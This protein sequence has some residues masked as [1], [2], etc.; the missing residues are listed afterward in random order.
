MYTRRE[1]L[2][3]FLG[4]AVAN[5]A[6]KAKPIALPEGRI[7]GA[8][9]ERGHKLRTPL[10][11]DIPAKRMRKR[12]IVIVGGGVAGLSAGWQLKRN[13][14][15]DFEVCELEDALGGTARG[16][17]NEVSVHPWGAHYVNEPMPEHHAMVELLTE[18]GVIED[19]E[20]QE[21]FLCREPEER[22]FYRGRWYEG[23]YLRAGASADDLAQLHRFEALVA[24]FVRFRDVTGHRG[25]AIPMATGSEAAEITVLDR[26]SMAEWMSREGFTSPRLLWLIDYACRDDYGARPQTTSAWAG[27]FYFAARKSTPTAESQNVITWPEGNGRLVNHLS[28]CIKEHTS[29]GQLIAAVEPRDKGVA[30][31]GLDRDDKAFGILADKVIFAAPQFVAPHVVRGLPVRDFTYGVWMVSNLT[32]DERPVSKGYP[33]SWDNVFYDS[34]SLGYV[35]ATHQ[36]G[37]DRG[38]TVITHYLPLTEGTPAAERKRLFALDHAAAADL[39]LTDIGRAHHDIRERCQRIDV[40]RWGHAMIRPDPGFIFGEA[41]KAARAPFRNVHFAHSDLSGIALFEEA[42]YRGLQAA[43]AV[44]A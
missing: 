3:A 8:A 35:V 5:S 6:C 39:V 9:F 42:F 25:F 22:L 17:K 28:Q 40:M 26:L 24:D 27:L 30:V 33:H 41:R 14:V 4:A 23:L 10:G 36:R 16:G 29:T 21:Q 32:L 15:S 20:V 7:V 1:I 44:R 18:M 37:R 13:G 11:F 2:T 19:G 43:D 34:P 31:Y 12:R 38:P